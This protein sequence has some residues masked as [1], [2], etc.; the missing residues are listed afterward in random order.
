M[1][2]LLQKI[3]EM[4]AKHK[5]MEAAVIESEENLHLERLNKR[6]KIS[7]SL[8]SDLYQLKLAETKLDF[9][10]EKTTLKRTGISNLSMLFSTKSIL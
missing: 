2:E 1:D 7:E 6:K 9:Q 3:K 10:I 8:Q 4:E 5:I